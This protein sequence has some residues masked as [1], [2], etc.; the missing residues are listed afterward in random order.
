[1]SNT[2][3]YQKSLARLKSFFENFGPANI[4]EMAEIYSEPT[5]FKDPFH[6]M[7]SVQNQMIPYF[8]KALTKLEDSRF[9]F[10]ESL[11]EGKKA[12]LI[13][14]MH[15][16]VKGHSFKIHGSS[17]IEFDDRGL[18]KKHRDYWDL[19]EELYDKLPVIGALFRGFKKIFG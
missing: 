10:H 7:T 15:F 12:F 6:E 17:Y 14:D 9:E 19:A 4:H 11:L 5:F 8:T 16:K 3:D 18:V 2:V 13:W 1:M